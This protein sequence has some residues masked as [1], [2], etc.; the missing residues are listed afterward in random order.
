ML[1]FEGLNVSSLITLFLVWKK[2]IL[3]SLYRFSYA[4]TSLKFSRPTW[5]SDE[6]LKRPESIYNLAVCEGTLIP[7]SVD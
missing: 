3:V 4:R 7:K 5:F 6:V 1:L 2:L